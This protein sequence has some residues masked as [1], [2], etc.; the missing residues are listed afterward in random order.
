MRHQCR[1]DCRSL[2]QLLLGVTIPPGYRLAMGCD[3]DLAIAIAIAN[4]DHGLDG[5]VGEALGSLDP[6]PDF[7][8]SQV[9]E[10]MLMALAQ[11]NMLTDLAHE[12]ML[13]GQAHEH[14]L[15][16]QAHDHRR[17]VHTPAGYLPEIR[18][19]GYSLVP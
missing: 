16:G 1:C 4:Q 13:M 2:F 15:I 3:P 12:H 9:H 19:A 8:L 14:T 5:Y 18:M 6:D 7:S 17:Y 10:H 11:E